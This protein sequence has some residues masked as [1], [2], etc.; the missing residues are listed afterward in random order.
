MS[1]MRKT[2]CFDDL[3]ARVAMI[4]DG[5]AKGMIAEGRTRELRASL[6]HVVGEEYADTFMSSLGQ[7]EPEPEQ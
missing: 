1:G 6:V 7:V 2:V 3:Q 5:W 4:F